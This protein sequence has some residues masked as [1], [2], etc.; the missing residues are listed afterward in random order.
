MPATPISKSPMVGIADLAKASD[1]S[2]SDACR[3]Y[4]NSFP[5][6]SG[7]A[8]NISA[9]V[10]AT[11]YLNGTPL[12]TMRRRDLKKIMDYRLSVMDLAT[13]WKDIALRHGQTFNDCHLWDYESWLEE[14]KLAR[15]KIATFH[16]YFGV[17]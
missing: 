2:L 3:R 14:N 9:L 6:P 17:I 16:R 15:A 7:S 1:L 12:G 5:G 8:N 13:T 4:L 10:G 11:D